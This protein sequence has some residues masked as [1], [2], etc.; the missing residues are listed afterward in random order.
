MYKQCASLRQSKLSAWRAAPADGRY[1]D[2]CKY[3]NCVLSESICKDNL[4][5]Q[6]KIKAEAEGRERPVGQ[7]VKAK[8]SVRS[9]LCKDECG[10]GCHILYWYS[11]VNTQSAV[12]DICSRCEC[13]ERR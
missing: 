13:F 9:I 12:V 8:M 11:Q 5:S 3:A 2:S 6:D 7:S 4:Q 1:V 10:C